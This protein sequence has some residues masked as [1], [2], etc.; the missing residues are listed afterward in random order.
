MRVLL[1]CK[2]CGSETVNWIRQGRIGWL[3]ITGGL[4][5]LVMLHWTLPFKLEHR[6]AFEGMIFQLIGL[7][8]AAIGIGKLRRY[9]NL[10]PVLKSIWKYLTEFRFLFISRPPAKLGAQSLSAGGALIGDAVL[11][12]PPTGTL[13][14]RLA[15]VEEQ[16]KSLQ[17]SLTDVRN[18]IAEGERGAAE[19]IKREASIRE[20]GDIK[21]E[22]KLKE[23][24]IGDW[25]LE[26]VGLVYLGVGIILG[27]VPT[28]IACLMLGAGAGSI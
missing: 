17:F 20:V 25:G 18:K 7:G 13:E 9:F 10:D 5:L 16:M 22:A 3:A 14:E 28:Q 23:T 24:A 12:T 4:L 1:W 19:A 21:S 2:R 11:Y 6:L 8:L 15:R 27:T 26:F